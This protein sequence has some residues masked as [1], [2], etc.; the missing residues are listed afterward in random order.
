MRVLITG[1]FL[2]L[3]QSELNGLK[4]SAFFQ[5]KKTRRQGTGFLD[6]ILVID[7]YQLHQQIQNGGQQESASDNAFDRSKWSGF[8][9][10]TIDC[11]CEN[12]TKWKCNSCQAEV[13][14]RG[15][16]LTQMN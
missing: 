14:D 3:R 9:Y 10:N 12:Q 5:S 6:Q 11:Q 16:K 2:T 1:L 8:T 7:L 4:T 13:M 15:L